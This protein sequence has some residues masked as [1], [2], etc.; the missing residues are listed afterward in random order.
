MTRTPIGAMSSPGSK[1]AGSETRMKIVHLLSFVGA[2]GA[3][4]G[5]VAV[6]REQCQEL[7]ARGHEV[8][9]LAGWDGQAHFSPEDVRTELRRALKPSRLGFGALISPGLWG[10]ARRATAQ[11]DIF[12]VH[13]ARD[14]ASMPAALAAHA[15]TPLVIQTHGM[16]RP[17]DRNAVRLFDR[18]LTERALSKAR[19]AF[20]LTAQ[21]EHDL[22]L[23]ARRSVDVAPIRNGVRMARFKATWED[24][25]LPEVLYCARLHDRKRPQ[26]FVRMASLLLSRGVKARFTL[27]GPDEG[28]LA[29]VLQMIQSERL[30]AH[31]KYEGACAPSNVVERMSRAQVYVL[32]SVN[33]P[34]PMSVLEAM[35]TGL[36][37]VITTKT[38][39]SKELS[40][41]GAALVAEPRAK[42]LADAV[43]DILTSRSRWDE[44]STKSLASIENNF[45]TR[46]VVDQLESHY[47]NL[48]GA[49]PG[50]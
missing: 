40:S 17:S 46:A 38:G 44:L 1:L 3:Y 6:A 28:Q 27:I 4:G 20:A 21:E 39:V 25:C 10:A 7:A 49:G 2:D 31:V 41:S 19:V 23:V 26:E 29:P 43:A 8:V 42:G 9:L 35:S 15:H 11:A 48:V 36:P 32:P 12:H 45:G 24:D 13:L 50:R 34:F 47:R 5:P 37:S 14:L 16:I 33:E 22:P 18:L 30:G